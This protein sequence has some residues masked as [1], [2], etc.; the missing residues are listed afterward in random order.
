MNNARVY[1]EYY[2]ILEKYDMLYEQSKNGVKFTKLM[3]IITSE[4]NIMS[5]YRILKK[6]KGSK[7]AGINNHNIS[8]LEKYTKDNLIKYVRNRLN[9]YQPQGIKRVYIPK[10]NGKQRPLGIPTIEDR[11]IQQCIKHV[12]EPIVEPKF[13]EHSYGFRPLRDSSHALFRMQFLINRCQLTYCID[14]D[15]EGFFDNVNHGKLL[16]QLW[17]L[18]VRDKKLIKIISLMLKD[19]VEGVPTTKGVPQGGIISPLLANIY[20]NE[21]DWWVAEQWHKHPLNNNSARKLK[22]TNM[23]EMYIIRYADDF[24][25]MCKNYTE[26]NKI[27]HA[28][29]QWLKERLDL[30]LNEDKTRI[31]NLKKNYSKFLGIE[32][33][34]RW[35]RNKWTATSRIDREEVENIKERVKKCVDNIC[36]TQNEKEVYMY[37]VVISG[38]HNYY[39]RAIQ[40]F[41]DFKEINWATRKYHKV[42]LS[43]YCKEGKWKTGTKGFEKY[44]Q[45]RYKT[46]KLG[47]TPLIPIC[48]VGYKRNVAVNKKKNLYIEEGRKALNIEELIL[49]DDLKYLRRNYN[50]HWNIEYFDNRISRYSMQM[51]KCAISKYYTTPQNGECHHVNPRFKGGKDNFDNLRWIDKTIHKGIHARNPDVIEKAILVMREHS[52]DS[53]DFSNMLKKFNYYR[54]KCDREEYKIRQN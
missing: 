4:E 41:N 48:D 24:K 21:L 2:G 17:N 38:M 50:T 35:R 49:K 42:R 18:G 14:F 28:T 11:L 33:K 5:A 36:K 20:L 31:V 29:G 39:S 53:K 22:Q 32:V 54:T 7:T 6:N 44:F 52:K 19:K 40:V 10:A 51:G 34:A 8:H 23:K 37:N 13:Y 45:G 47:N 1:N 27:Y 43:K 16:K 26:A 12:L 30:E 9:N 46:F 3:D 25:I 15:I